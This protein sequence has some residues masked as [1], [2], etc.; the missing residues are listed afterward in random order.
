MAAEDAW[1]SLVSAVEI[2]DMDDV[3]DAVQQYV[4]A[5]PDTTYLDLDKAFR[6]QDVALYLV[7]TKKD[8]LQTM[9]NMDFQGNLD[10]TY[11]VSYRFDFKPA[12]PREADAWPKSIEENQERLKDAGEVVNR[13]LHKCSNCDELGH[14]AKHCPQEKQE[15]ERVVVKCFNCGEEGHRIRDCPEPRQ[16]R[17]ACKNCGKSGH[18]AADCKSRLH[19]LTIY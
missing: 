4:K 12:R 10:K 16:D 6:A 11:T 19:P 15:R 5:C 17:F 9:T 14:I 2:C 3:K 7:A 8:L 18:K 1:K 13:G